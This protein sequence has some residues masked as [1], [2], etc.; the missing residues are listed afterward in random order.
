M[1]LF[2]KHNNTPATPAAP[3]DTKTHLIDLSKKAGIVLEKKKMGS[4]EA[5]VYLVLDYSGSMS[6]YYKDGTVQAFTERVL[7]IAMNLDD[8]GSIPVVVFSTNINAVEEVSTENYHNSVQ[9]IQAKAGHMGTTNYAAAMAKV[10]ELHEGVK[11]PGLVIFQTDG[12]PDSKAAAERAIC[13]LANLPLFWQF[14][15]FGDD[16][17]FEFLKKLDEL[18]VPEKRVIDNAGFF[19]AGHNPKAMSDEELYEN[20]LEEFP[21]WLAERRRR[22]I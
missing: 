12:A 10:A 19:A 5:A 21:V 3:A 16:R 4:V 14:V 2:N 8:D 1:G 22:G 9:R 6:R 13:D 15:G 7:G 11:A 20:L 18:K 17:N